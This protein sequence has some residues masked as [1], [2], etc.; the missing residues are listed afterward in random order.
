MVVRRIVP[1]SSVVCADVNDEAVLLNVETGIYFGLDGLGAQ[2]W[3]LIEEGA[4]EEE[5]L[6]RL[7][8]EYEVTPEQLHGDLTEFLTQL[9][10]HGLIEAW[11]A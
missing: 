9:D 3:K 4:N 8:A 11:G 6:S 5:I 1:S 10:A 7:L 2:I